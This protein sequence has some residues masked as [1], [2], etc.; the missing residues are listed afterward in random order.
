MSLVTNWDGSVLVPANPTN[1]RT[2]KLGTFLSI[3]NI[4]TYY[5]LPSAYSGLIP[6]TSFYKV[7]PEYAGR[8][9]LI[10][11]DVYGDAALWWVIFW[12]NAIVDPFARP[13]SGEVINI[14]DIQSLQKLLS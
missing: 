14:I 6:I 4:N 10:A 3:N 13:T 2:T 1:D 5:P 11:L 7:P 8:P 9:D 12:A